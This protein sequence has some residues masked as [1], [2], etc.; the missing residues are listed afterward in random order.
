MTSTSE[1]TVYGLTEEEVKELEDDDDEF[2]GETNES[3]RSVNLSLKVT[4][5]KVRKLKK[6]SLMIV[7]WMLGY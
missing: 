7:S 2:F 4:L 3:R 6:V 5:V 1:R